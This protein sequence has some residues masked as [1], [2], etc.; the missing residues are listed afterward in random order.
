VVSDVHS[1]LIALEAVIA[2]L[3][4]MEPGVVLHGGDLG[5]AGA[6]PAAVIDGVREFG[7]RGVMS[8]TEDMP[9]DMK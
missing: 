2:D 6:S 9:R 1:T 7:W 8:N 4:E 3:G 5:D